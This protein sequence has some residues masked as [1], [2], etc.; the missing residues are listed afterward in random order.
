MHERFNT[1]RNQSDDAMIFL[2]LCRV[3]GTKFN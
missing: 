2:S 3:A 1:C